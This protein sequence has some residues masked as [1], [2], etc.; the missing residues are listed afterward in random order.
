[1]TTG[2]PSTVPAPDPPDSPDAWYA[3]AVRAQYE[4]S[5]DVVV[6]IRS[7]RGSQAARGGLRSQFL[8]RG[9]FY[10]GR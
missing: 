3:P 6:T 2:D 4:V 5:P 7:R 8:S 9:Y 1:M 10:P